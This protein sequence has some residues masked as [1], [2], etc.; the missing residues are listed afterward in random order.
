MLTAYQLTNGRLARV[1]DGDAVQDAVWID[2]LNPDPQE[3]AQ[4]TALGLAVP[5]LAE[6][7]EIEI[8]NRLYRATGADYMTVVLPGFSDSAAPVSG[9]VSFILS[10]ARLITVR[11]HAPRPFLTYPERADKSA[12]G[13]ASADHVF[14]GLIEEIIARLADLLEGAGKTLDRLS[15]DVFGTHDGRNPDDLR[16]V[17]QEIGRQGELLGRVRLGLLTVERA[18]SFFEQTLSR[19][20]KALRGVVAGGQRDI[21]ALGVHADFLSTR[22]SLIDDATLGMINLQQNA[23]VRIFSLVAVLFM[24]PTLVASVYGMN[25]AHMPELSRTWGYPAALAGMVAS[26]V[27]TYWFFKW[28]RWL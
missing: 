22:I 8:S 3:T 15:S 19:G 2:L 14:V 4:V 26:A 20:S 10:E 24:P 28:R 1:T 23:T 11:H 13:C 9:P 5:T 16:A 6:M 18:L 27:L 21:D 12:A 17:L 25:F 7:E